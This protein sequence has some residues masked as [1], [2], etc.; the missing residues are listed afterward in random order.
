MAGIGQIV[1]ASTGTIAQPAR[2]DVSVG[3]VLSTV[4]KDHGPV[5]MAFDPA[6]RATF[7]ANGMDFLYHALDG[8]LLLTGPRAPKTAQTLASTA[9]RATATLTCSG[10]FSD[11]DLIQ[12]GKPGVLG[13]GYIEVKTT[14]NTAS[15]ADQVKIGASLTASLLN[16]K[17]FVNDVGQQ[18]DTWWNGRMAAFGQDY[19]G[20]F[21]NPALND[22]EVTA[23]DATTASFRAKTYGTIGNSYLA[24]K[25]TGAAITSFGTSSLMSGGAVGTGTEPGTG[26]YGYGRTHL[27]KEDFYESGISPLAELTQGVNCNVNQT[28]FVD[29]PSRDGIT[30]DRWYRTETGGSVLRNGKDVVVGTSEPYVDNLSDVAITTGDHFEYEDDLHRPYASGYPVRYR[31]NAFF[32][33]CLFGVGA[34]LAQDYTA[35]TANVAGPD[36]TASDQVTLSAS[37]RPKEDWIGRAFKVNADAEDYL[38]VD[39]VEAT[40]VL[41]LNRTYNGTTNTTASYTVRDNR[42]PS[43][44]YHSVSLFPNSYPPTQSIQGIKTAS[45]I[46]AT[47]IGATEDAVLVWTRTNLWRL[48]GDPSSA[49]RPEFI[50]DKCGSWSNAGVVVGPLG[51]LYWIGP[52]GVMEMSKAAGAIPRCISNL[53]VRKGDIARGITGTLNRINAEYADGICGFYDPVVNVIRWFVPLDGEQF[54]NFYIELNVQ[55][56]AFYEGTCQAISACRLIEGV[57]GAQVSVLGTAFGNI[58]QDRLGNADGGFGTELVAAVSSYNAQTK[59][60]TVSG[61]PFSSTATAYAG[62]SVVH[63]AKSTGVVQRGVVESGTSSTLVLAWGLGTAP[64][65]GDTIS[66]GEI[67][68]ILESTKAD[69]GAP[70]VEKRVTSVTLGFAPGSGGRAWLAAASDDDT[71]DVVTLRSTGNADYADLKDLDGEHLF[72]TRLERGRRFQLH[73]MA[74]GPGVAMSFLAVVP[75]VKPMKQAVAG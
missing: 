58:L 69:R 40:R 73:V 19:K 14:L 45:T 3:S 57:D 8:S 62:A 56:G 15:S 59:T 20:A 44:V 32:K 63:I 29:A 31:Y 53:P 39:V 49:F 25:V 38:I 71:P 75:N 30:H 33:G 18:G 6:L 13:N 36:T 4:L 65:A 67:P 74:L 72:W 54:N 23:S 55:T 48:V 35:G 17:N 47:G 28:D 52:N 27:R 24:R 51:A 43:E 21:K 37:A 1:L 60:I 12:V 11:G 10:N 70:D 7:L 61:T 26:T 42:D 50:A 46:G 68:V 2:I 41:T 9:V 22:V 16:I 34:V 64:V 66:L 5:S